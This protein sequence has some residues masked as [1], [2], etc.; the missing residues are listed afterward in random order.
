MKDK[1]A[2]KAIIALVKAIRDSENLV[3]LKMR[4]TVEIFKALTETDAE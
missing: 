2:R 3:E 1:Q 4:L